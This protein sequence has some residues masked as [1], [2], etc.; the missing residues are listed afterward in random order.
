MPVVH[1]YLDED[2]PLQLAGLLTAYGAIVHHPSEIGA[3]KAADPIHLQ[4]CAQERWVLIT[5]NRKD[6]F[7]LHGLWMTLHYW[8]IIAQP[9]SGILTVFRQILP[10]EWAPA[11][12]QLLEQ[13]DSL[14]GLMFAWQDSTGEWLPQR[15]Y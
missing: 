2:V 4:R 5:Q 7:R 15:V 9:H 14:D 11:I 8:Q 6:L 1:V 10:S 12:R 3:L 13:H